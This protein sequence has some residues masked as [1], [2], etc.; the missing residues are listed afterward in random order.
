[1][2][3]LR[4]L[5]YRAHFLLAC[6]AGGF[7]FL[8]LSA[9]GVLY[10]ALAPPHLRQRGA[11]LFARSFGA[12]MTTMLGWRLVVEERERF[13][14][15]PSVIL[16]NHQSNLDIVTWGSIYPERT[17]TIGKRE[18]AVLPFFGWF[19]RGTGNLFIDRSNATRAHATLRDAAATIR[20]KSLSVWMFPEGHRNQ[21]P[22]L[23]PLKKG[24]F[25]LAIAAQA[26]IV[27]AIA[28]PI[29]TVLDA[30]RLLVRPGRIRVRILP[31]IPTEGLTTDD[32][33]ALM[34]RTR[35]TMQEA[36]D[37][38]RASARPAIS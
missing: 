34:A 19:F 26:P 18:L 8:A 24:P 4:R 33:E 14:I 25:H 3:F 27:L 28:E 12:V 32:V 17:V 30:R 16:V 35:A 31:P 9:V 13:S 37:G 36:F 11:V 20:E 29:G 10:V 21:E 7:A 22:E 23:L 38:L 1:M 15:H 2:P 5:A 6:L